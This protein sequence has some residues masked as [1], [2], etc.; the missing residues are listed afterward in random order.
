M[1]GTAKLF[2]IPIICETIANATFSKDIMWFGGIYLDLLSQIVD[3]K[4]QI[5][6]FVVIFKRSEKRT[7]CWAVSRAKGFPKQAQ[8]KNLTFEMSCIGK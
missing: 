5:M 7:S 4:P 2:L 1:L 6:G 8:N 3:V